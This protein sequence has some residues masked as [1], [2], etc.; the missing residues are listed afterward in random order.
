VERPK[1]QE[2]IDAFK[3]VHGKRVGDNRSIR[4]L[5][6]LKDEP[7]LVT[8]HTKSP[9]RFCYT[10][11]RCGPSVSL[12]RYIREA[13]GDVLEIGIHSHGE[14]TAHA[15]IRLAQA[16][17]EYSPAFLEGANFS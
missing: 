4:E 7:G 5:F 3:K 16:A 2:S 6:R 11:F 14:S 8:L 1:E 15:T 9:G 13:V 10:A 17:E 12:L